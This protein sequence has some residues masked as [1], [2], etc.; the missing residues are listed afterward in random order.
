MTETAEKIPMEP[1]QS[2]ALSAIGYNPN[3][4]ILAV[5]F[6]SG[7]VHHYADVSEVEHANL[8][9]ADSLGSHF[10]KFIRQHHQAAKMTGVCPSCGAQHGWLGE[11]C[12]DCGTAEYA[13]K[14]PK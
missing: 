11:T 1:V 10:G 7:A 8:M 14:E 2:S 12:S 9:A 3:K 5:T 6:S 13:A 4:R